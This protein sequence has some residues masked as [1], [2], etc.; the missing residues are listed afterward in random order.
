MDFDISAAGATWIKQDSGTQASLLGGAMN[1]NGDVAVVGGNGTLLLRKA[2]ETAFTAKHL[3]LS[4]GQ[5]PSFTAVT[6]TS[7]G[8]MLASDMGYVHYRVQ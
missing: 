1:E 4:A 2:N 8:F 7:D 3:L 5:T 6:P